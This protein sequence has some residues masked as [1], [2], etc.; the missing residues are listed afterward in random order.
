ME[1]KRLLPDPSQ[2]NSGFT[3]GMIEAGNIDLRHRPAVTNGD[4][5]VSSVRSISVGTDRGEVLIPT[6]SED[7]RIMSNKEAIDQ[8]R[9]TGRH[10]GVF[11]TPGQA[12]AYADQVHQE[13]ARMGALSM[14]LRNTSKK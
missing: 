13:Q 3:P 4:G 11:K 9:K 1:N 8:Y 14:A 6:V 7:A 12:T 10:M 5:R 2:P